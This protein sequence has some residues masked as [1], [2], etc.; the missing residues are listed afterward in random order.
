[1]NATA[2]LNPPV[3]P[4]Q[5]LNPVSP[6]EIIYPDSDGLPM[7]DN[8]KQFR[9][10]V[11]IQGGIAALFAHDPNVFVAG[12]LLWYPV[13]GDN[14]IRVAP[15]VMVVFGRPP[16]DWGSYRQWQEDGLAPQV[17]FEV[18]SPGNTLAEMTR[19]FQFYDRYGVEEYYIYDPD[20]GELDGSIRRD[21]RL[22]SVQQMQG[23]ISPRL[24]VR[25]TLLG[26]DLMLYRPDGRR[27]ETFL[28]LEQRAESEHQ[29]A[30]RLAERLRALGVDPNAL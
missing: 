21:G 9:Y 8:T 1:M 25:F 6:A 29:R 22:E 24:S 10:I 4:I 12:D 14:T 11:M 3:A 13:E 2:T 7:A 19:K 26:I 16:G 28:E 15:D 23:W 17:V 27:F 18:L 5:K 30:E 20:R